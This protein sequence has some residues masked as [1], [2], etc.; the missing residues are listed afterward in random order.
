MISEALYRRFYGDPRGPKYDGTLL[1][2]TSLR[3]L[4]RPDSRVLNLGAGPTSGNPVKSLK[5][6]V[7]QLV[8][9]DIDPVV[10]HNEEVDAAVV[11]ENYRLP[12]PDESFDLAF[13]DYVLEHVERPAPFLAE[14]YRVLKP[15]GRYLFRTPNFYH[16]VALASS[17]TPHWFH[18]LVANRVRGLAADAHQPWPTFYRLNSRRAIRHQA[19]QA[20]FAKADMQMIEYQPSYLMFHVVPFLAGVAYERV[21]NST[22]MLAGLR[23]NIF[24]QLTK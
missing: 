6:E 2:Y 20:G 11:I 8:G 1:F 24:G 4:A 19:R 16:Y 7:A 15:D 13:S 10:L 14:V 5:G 22:E 12:F 23:A 3:Q 18:E 17:G 21:V 9:A